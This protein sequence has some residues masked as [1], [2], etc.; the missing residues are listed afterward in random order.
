MAQNNSSLSGFFRYPENL[1]MDI[2]S[3]NMG[4]LSKILKGSS[5]TSSEGYHYHGYDDNQMDQWRVNE[6]DEEIDCAIAL[7]LVEE[8]EKRKRAINSEFQLKEDEQLA[9]AL[10]ESFSTE[11]RPQSIDYG[12]RN[13][14]LPIMLPFSTGYRVCTGCNNEIGFGRFLSCMGKVWHPECFKCKSCNLPILDYQYSVSGD[15]PYHRACYKEH[16]L[17]KC[18]VCNQSIPSNGA[19]LIEYRAHPLWDQKYCPVHDTDGTPQCCSCERMEPQGSGYISLGDGRKLCLECLDSSVMDT[20]QCQPLYLEIQEFYESLGM[21]IQQQVPLLLVE[22]QALNEAMGGE[23]HGHHRM[24]ET[25]GLCLSE[26]QTITTVLKRPKL[27]GR[28]G[29]M[30]VKSE[31]YKLTRHC[32]VTAIL[33]LYGLPRLLTGSI[34]AHEMM[35]AWLRLKGYRNLNP[36]IEEGIC[37]VMAHKWLVTQL[38]TGENSSQASSSA[39]SA[40]RGNRSPFDLKLGKFFKNQVET[41]VSPVYGDGFRAAN[42]AVLKYGLKSTLDHLCSHDK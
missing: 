32:E 34:L 21:K 9:R 20:N 38:S 22:R 12:G 40:Y 6:N 18:G 35:H 24:S 33:V 13:Y 36:Q 7:S 8:E 1:Y 16:C 4:W 2:T 23:K 10:Q 31:P 41:D 15:Y 25:R 39:R 5:N 27:W 3:T 11:A 14:G 29:N 42:K 28:S 37:Q 26:E 17:P 30:N 19:G